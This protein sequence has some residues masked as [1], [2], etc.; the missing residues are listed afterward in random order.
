LA[1]SKENQEI[2]KKLLD[3]AINDDPK[4]IPDEFVDRLREAAGGF[5]DDK[6]SDELK[7]LLQNVFI[8][9]MRQLSKQFVD[10]WLKEAC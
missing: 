10:D 4:N 5:L 9:K 7:R 2:M 6:P 3:R 8:A 1:Q